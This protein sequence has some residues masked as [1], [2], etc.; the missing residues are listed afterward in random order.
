MRNFIAAQ[1]K[2][3]INENDSPP[4]TQLCN[5]RNTN[6]CSLSDN[7]HEKNI[8]YQ[9]TVRSSNSIMNY[10]G[11][12]ETDFITRY[13]NQTHSFRNRSKCKATELSKF[14]WECK[15]VGINPFHS[16]EIGLS[17]IIVQT[18]K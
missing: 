10:F 6:Y 11:L 2:K 16:L 9:A 17:R 3:L 1:N 8:I 7:C 18:R 14:V 12:C 15:N 13:Y 4:K 5:C